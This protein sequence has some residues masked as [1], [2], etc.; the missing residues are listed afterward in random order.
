MNKP[1]EASKYIE[2]N[3]QTARRLYGDKLNDNREVVGTNIYFDYA[4]R[5]HEREEQCNEQQN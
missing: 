4:W 5:M 3:E 1:F 2:R